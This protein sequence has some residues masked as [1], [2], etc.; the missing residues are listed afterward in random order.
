[1]SSDYIYSLI[2]SSLQDKLINNLKKDKDF[3]D[4]NL[5]ELIDR[6]VKLILNSDIDFTKQKQ[7]KSGIKRP[8]GKMEQLDNGW[9][10]LNTTR[11][12]ILAS[13]IDKDNTSIKYECDDGTIVEFC[14]KYAY[15]NNE[16]F[17]MWFDNQKTSDSGIKYDYPKNNGKLPVTWCELI[18]NQDYFINSEP[19]YNLWM[20]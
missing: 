18:E 20:N 4:K 17:K 12:K 13:Y 14:P 9:N 1:M 6:R 11:F 16:R 15:K 7:T 10:I 5:N 19:D 3:K 8:H 2:K